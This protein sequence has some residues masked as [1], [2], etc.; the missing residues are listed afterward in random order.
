MNVTPEQIAVQFENHEQEIKSLKHRM[1]ERE[2]SD[3][4]LIELTTSVKTLGVNMEYMVKE[5]QK[6]GERLERLEHEPL[7]NYKYY[8]RAVIGCIITG[9]I[10]AIIGA[11]LGM[12]LR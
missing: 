10:G 7:D 9:I 2:K 11:V 4:T 5:Q 12:I 6:Q 1:D 3:K 8:K